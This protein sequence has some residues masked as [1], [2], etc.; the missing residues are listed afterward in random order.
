MLKE[1]QSEVDKREFLC[2]DNR[3]EILFL[4]GKAKQAISE[5][6]AHQLRSVHQDLR[7]LDILQSLNSSSVLIVQDFAMKFMPSH[8]REAQSDFFGKRGISWHVSVCHRKVDQRLEAQTLIHILET[9]LQDSETVVLIME[10]LLRSLKEQHPEIT[11]AYFRQNNGGCYHSSCSILSARVLS[12]R[13][14]I[15]VRQIDFSDPQGGK[16]TCDR[17]AAQ[18]KA[19]VKSYV[20]EGNSVTTPS[21]L[22][23]AIES[24]GGISGVRVAVLGVNTANPRTYKL[25]GINTLNNF[26]FN[27]QVFYAFRAY[28]IGPGKFFQWTEFEAGKYNCISEDIHF[29]WYLVIKGAT[30]R[31]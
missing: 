23:T 1:I 28:G 18:V 12:A 26:S 25:E 21:D 9:G 11:S 2:D 5:W 3:D 13:S 8:Y 4:V 22:K 17:K 15:Q 10:H 29:K 16:G 24:R 7:R 31:L 27:D 30:C 20:N 19:H 14:G 6:K